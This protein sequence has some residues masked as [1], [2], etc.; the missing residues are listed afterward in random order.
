VKQ[1]ETLAVGNA[2]A[3]QVSLMLNIDPLIKKAK[4]KRFAWEAP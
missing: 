3:R 2:A 4:K 1:I